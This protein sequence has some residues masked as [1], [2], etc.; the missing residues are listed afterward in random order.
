[1]LCQLSIILAFGLL[2][3]HPEYQVAVAH[4]AFRL[5]IQCQIYNTLIPLFLR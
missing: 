2:R 3:G 4:G 1:M 5:S